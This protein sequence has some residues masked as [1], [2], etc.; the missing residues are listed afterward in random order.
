MRGAGRGGHA[1]RHLLV[2]RTALRR[3]SLRRR[4]KRHAARGGRTC[5]RDGGALALIEALADGAQHAARGRRPRF[6]L[7]PSSSM[8]RCRDR[9]A[10]SSAR[11]STTV[12]MRRNGRRAA[13]TGRDPPRRARRTGSEYPVIFSKVPDCV[14]GPGEPIRI[15]G[16]VSQAIDYEAELAVV[17]G[18]GGRG[19]RAS[20]AHGARVRLH[21]L[22]RRDG[23]RRP[24]P[25]QAVAAREVGRHVRAD[26]AVARHGRRAR[27]REHARALL[28]ER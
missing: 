2:G 23:A 25:P 9:A 4:Q 15:P 26:G 27:R 20:R 10:T 6:P 16:G 3:A 8:R 11:A 5:A 7:P 19:I 18:K 21:D 28:G 12:P 22:Q 1:N 14:I 13:W 17:I 24:A